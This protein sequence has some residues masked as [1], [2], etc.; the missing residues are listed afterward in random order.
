M[1]QEFKIF[2]DKNVLSVPSGN[3]FFV[4]T[5]RGVSKVDPKL[6]LL[7]FSEI[8]FSLKQKVIIAHN[9]GHDLKK[10]SQ[11]IILDTPL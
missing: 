5:N 1:K 7:C 11:K 3:V 6:H 9:K 2:L 4:H 10:P 8:Q